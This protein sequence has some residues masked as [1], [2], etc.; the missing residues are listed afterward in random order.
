[1]HV[2]LLGLSSFYS[3]IISSFANTMTRWK[4][5]IINSFI[6]TNEHG[7]KINS[8]IIENRN[9]TIKCIKHNSNGYTNWKRFRNRVLYVLNKDTTYHLYPKEGENE[10]E[11]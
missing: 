1:M 4:T 8:G 5:E 6:V 3:N 11:Q 9:R 2:S 7:R 10:N